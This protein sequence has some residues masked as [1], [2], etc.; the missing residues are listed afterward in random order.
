MQMRLDLGHKTTQCCAAL[1]EKDRQSYTLLQLGWLLS[2]CCC[3]RR[4]QRHDTS[5]SAWLGQL[6][7]L[8]DFQNLKFPET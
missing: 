6:G 3:S 8:A 5:S 4:R 2:S 1:L 7:Q